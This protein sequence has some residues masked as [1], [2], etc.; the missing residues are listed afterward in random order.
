MPSSRKTHRDLIAPAVGLRIPSILAETGYNPRRL[1]IEITETAL[2][3]NITLAHA[4]IDQLRAAGIRIALDDFG[5]GYSTLSQLLSFRLEDQDRLQL[6]VALQ[7]KQRW[8]GNRPRHPWSRDRIWLDDYG[9]RHRRRRA[10]GIFESQWMYRR[11]GISL[12]QSGLCGR[13]SNPSKPHAS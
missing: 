9:R 8:P 7:R 12:Q 6:C 1:E 3:E 10:T 11:A 4:A 5:T 13:Y 2:I